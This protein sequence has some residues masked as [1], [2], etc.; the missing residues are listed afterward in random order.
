MTISRTRS[1]RARTLD[2]FATQARWVAWREEER[3]RQ[4]GTVTKTKIPYD[5]NRDQQARIP[6]E[7]ATW[8]TREQAEQRWLQLNHNGRG[9]VGL[10]LGAL[11]DGTLLMGIDLDDCF[12]GEC[13]AD[14]AAEII[15]RFNSYNKP[16]GTVKCSRSSSAS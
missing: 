3:R 16:V 8:G 4:D 2:D 7:P 1:N 6:T 5:P 11:P 15:R 10:V 9:G 13:I 14:W 12:A